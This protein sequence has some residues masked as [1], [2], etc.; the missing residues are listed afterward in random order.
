[1]AKASDSQRSDARRNRTRLLDAARAVLKERGF[2]AE[3]SEIAARARVGSGTIYRNFASKEALVLEVVREMAGASGTQLLAIA[4]NVSDARECLR[5]AIEVGFQQVK[6]YGKLATD[7]VAGTAPEPYASSMKHHDALRHVFTL[8][9]RR[10][11]EQ[12]H[13]RADLDVDYAVAVWFALVA[14]SAIGDLLQIRPIEA[15]ADLT[16]EFLLAGLS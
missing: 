12:G 4:A 9:I 15:V 14:P 10:G 7:V 6:K 1:V 11:M 8:L 3:I 16:S 13:F 2:D 5:Q